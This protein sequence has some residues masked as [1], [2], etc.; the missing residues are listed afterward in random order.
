M[1]VLSRK[2]GERILIGDSIEVTVVRVAGGAI[3]LGVSAPPEIKVIRAELE[4][5]DK[6]NGDIRAAQNELGDA[7]LSPL[8]V[9]TEPT[10]QRENKG[11]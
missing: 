10:V 5:K 7:S 2:V 1:L 3:R 8:E 4:K 9:H 6:A 11:E